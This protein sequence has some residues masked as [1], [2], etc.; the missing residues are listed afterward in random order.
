MKLIVGPNQSAG[1]TDLRTLSDGCSLLVLKRFL[2]KGREL[3]R[4]PDSAQ[5][6]EVSCC[7]SFILC[8]GGFTASRLAKTRGQVSRIRPKDYLGP[9]QQ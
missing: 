7:H 2:R 5:K 3:R 4:S 9:I 6:L 8:L 1:T